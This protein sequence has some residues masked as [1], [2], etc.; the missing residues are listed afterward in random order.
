MPRTVRSEHLLSLTD[1]CGVAQHASFALANRHHGYCLDDNARA[2]LL[3]AKLSRLRP[4]TP[5]EQR[6][7]RSYAAFVHHCWCADSGTFRNF[8]GF[9]RCWIDTAGDE[10]AA[11]RAFWSLAAAYANAPLPGID[12][13]ARTLLDQML[14]FPQAFSSP[15]GWAMLLIALGD[16]L[17]TAGEWKEAASLYRTLAGRLRMRFADAARPGWIWWEDSLAYENARLCEAAIRAGARL[18]D[19]GLRDAG[20]DS[21]RWL[22]GWQYDGR[23]FRPVGS[24]SFG[25]THEPPARFDQQPVD[26]AATVDACLAAAAVDGDPCWMATANAA[27]A[28]FDGANDLGAPLVDL[29]EGLCRD[30]LH[31]D[32]VNANAGAES[33]LCYL[34]ACCSHEGGKLQ[35]AGI[36]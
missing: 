21:L 6:M 1:D 18:G 30:G 2:L 23:L 5:I 31:P 26:A 33:T 36:D 13:W 24:D 9:D 16:C 10:D 29:S 12:R 15:R 14:A 4:L 27:M 32:R 34:L 11:G 8:M 3:M 25:R 7:T 17:D 35:G 22:N 28:W 19:A 20:L